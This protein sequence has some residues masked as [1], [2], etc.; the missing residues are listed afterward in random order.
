M[1]YPFLLNWTPCRF[2]GERP[3]FICPAKGCQRRVAIL[4]SG[5][6]YACRHCHQL[7]YTSQREA[8]YDRALRQAEKIRGEIRLGY[9]YF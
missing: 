7:A 2:G 5:S 9:W 6:I 1:R 8:D 3:W 4:Y